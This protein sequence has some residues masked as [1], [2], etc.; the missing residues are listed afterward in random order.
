MQS[1]SSARR[2]PAAAAP[3]RQFLV[4]SRRNK[5]AAAAFLNLGGGGNV[6]VKGVVCLSVC[7][8]RRPACPSTPSLPRQEVPLPITID[9]SEFGG[10]KNFCTNMS[11]RSLATHGSQRRAH[12][13]AR[14]HH[15]G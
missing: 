8:V 5:V 7:P 2:W 15:L 14:R 1:L 10:G 6:V 13:R 3:F 12:A 11:D 4:I 9:V